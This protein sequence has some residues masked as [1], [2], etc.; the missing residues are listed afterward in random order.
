M[1]GITAVRKSITE[2]ASGGGES[3]FDGVKIPFLKLAHG[4]TK[5]LFLSELDVNSDGTVPPVTFYHYYKPP[6]GYTINGKPVYEVAWQ[7]GDEFLP[8]FIAQKEE[9]GKNINPAYFPYKGFAYVINLTALKA[10]KL[11]LGRGG[12]SETPASKLEGKDALITSKDFGGRV[13]ADEAMAAREYIK[14][15]QKVLKMAEENEVELPEYHG[16]FIYNFNVSITKDIAKFIDTLEA[17][18]EEFTDIKLTDW[19][20][21]LT[22]EGEGFDT[23]Y[24]LSINSPADEIPQDDI[25]TPRKFLENNDELSD[26]SGLID[27]K[28]YKTD[29]EEL[30]ED[31]KVSAVAEKEAG[32]W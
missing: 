7:D 11:F 32:E 26:F 10:V 24:A 28:R 8:E 19:V 5:I 2:K 20:F 21:D 23:E 16:I 1:A 15:Y 22:K 6:Q 30:E 29:D 14:Q 25:N 3:S 9:E 27:R 17:D 4:K 13:N 18:G 31:F 12:N